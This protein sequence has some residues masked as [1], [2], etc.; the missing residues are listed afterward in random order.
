METL[1]FSLKTQMKKLTFCFLNEVKLPSAT[2][3]TEID[4]QNSSP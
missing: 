3:Y 1:S 2:C 4:A